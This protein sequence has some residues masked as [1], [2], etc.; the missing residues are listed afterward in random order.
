MRTKHRDFDV[1]FDVNTEEW[2]CG[3][4]A[5]S[6]ASLSKLKTAIDREGKKRRQVDVEALYL[7]ERYWK[8]TYRNSL[9]VVK[10]V[11][12]REGDQRSSASSYGRPSPTRHPVALKQLNRSPR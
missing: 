11:L 2:K 3:A 6:N 1:E 10:I 5:L 4:L 12:L 8:G 7:R 9:A